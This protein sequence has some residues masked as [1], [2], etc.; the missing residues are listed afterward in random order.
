M[1]LDRQTKEQKRTASVCVS[2]ASG[3]M[4]QIDKLA[5]WEDKKDSHE[6]MF[7]MCVHNPKHIHMH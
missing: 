2:V 4:C 3:R 6:I 7:E 5:E 1:L